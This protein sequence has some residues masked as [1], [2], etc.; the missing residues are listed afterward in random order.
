MDLTQTHDC[1]ENCQVQ[2][3]HKYTMDYD[4]NDGIK[5]WIGR[6]KA[7][8]LLVVLSLSFLFGMLPVLMIGMRWYFEWLQGAIG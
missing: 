3:G 5:L 2:H 7:V 4:A 6:I 8:G 1:P